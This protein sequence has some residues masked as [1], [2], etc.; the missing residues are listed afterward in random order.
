MLPVLTI[1]KTNYKENVCRAMLSMAAFI[2]CQKAQQT[3]QPTR[4]FPF[5]SSFANRGISF[6]ISVE[7]TYTGEKSRWLPQRGGSG[8]LL[9]VRAEMV[10]ETDCIAR[11]LRD[12]RLCAYLSPVSNLVLNM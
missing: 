11:R 9:G 6:C 4:S 10:F 2:M 12:K 5:V 1:T 8:F 3:T 7:F